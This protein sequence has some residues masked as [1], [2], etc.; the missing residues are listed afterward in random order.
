[1]YIVF[2]GRLCFAFWGYR[3]RGNKQR[4]LNLPQ[5]V[6]QNNATTPTKALD[7]PMKYGQVSHFRQNESKVNEK[8]TADVKTSWKI[9]IFIAL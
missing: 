7:W 1:M 9:H 6:P 4:S 2:W 3:C 8:M 5:F